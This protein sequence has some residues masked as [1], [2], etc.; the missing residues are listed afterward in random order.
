MIQYGY[1]LANKGGSQS[2]LSPLTQLYPLA[3]QS[4]G[5]LVN[6]VVGKILNLKISNV[7]TTY[8]LIKLYSIKFSGYNQDPVISLI[9]E[10]SISGSEFTYSDDG[11][12][13]TTLT[14]SE[15][16][17]LGSTPII[18]EALVSKYNRLILGNIK[19]SYFDV[20]TSIYDTRAYR[21]P[22]NSTSTRIKNKDD[23]G[24]TTIAY[25]ASLAATHD[26]ICPFDNLYL[27]KNNSTIYGASGPNIT[28][29]VNQISLDNPRNVLKSNESYR[30][31]IEFFNKFGQTTPPKWITDIYIPQGNLNGLYNTLKVTLSNTST[32]VSA[33]VVG[34]R[35]L[36]VDR[37]E[38]DKT[39]LCQ[40]IVNPSSFQDYKNKLGKYATVSYGTTAADAG[41][42]KLPSPFMRNMSDLQDTYRAP[43]FTTGYPTINRITHGYPIDLPMTGTKSEHP[44]PEI[45]KQDNA[46][47]IHNSYEESRLFQLY[48]PEITF[49]EPNFSEGLKFKVVGSVENVLLNCGEW[50]KQYLTEDSYKYNVTATGTPANEVRASGVISLFA[51]AKSLTEAAIQ[52]KA[53]PNQNGLLGGAGGTTKRMNNYHYW[54]KYTFNSFSSS[55][56]FNILGTPM[57]SGAGESSKIYTG[58]VANVENKYKFSNHLYTMVTDKN[59][60]DAD[61]TD[62][63]IL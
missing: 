13:I 18:P 54:R 11:R 33:G 56:S 19:E 49:Q 24:Y 42:T 27:Y 8:D 26:C 6:E 62:D 15:L 22:I 25:N 39:I 38:Q 3:K 7:D 28:V 59:P 21:F 60:S 17:F 9:A 10:E 1:N 58:T 52:G 40:G 16:L 2:A 35:V 46:N 23:V 63:L 37:T 31:G 43:G 14:S 55:N 53:E 20:A 29:E 61:R 50:C 30:I 12:I 32:L 47:S 4:K 36:R 51:T 41:W 57:L 48:S 45:I 5:G 44:Y 34:W